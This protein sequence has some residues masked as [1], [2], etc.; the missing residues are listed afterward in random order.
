MLVQALK[1]SLP[2]THSGELEG[3]REGLDGQLEMVQ[4]TF[5]CAFMSTTIGFKFLEFQI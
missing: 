4:C 1:I 2:K 5:P 3:W